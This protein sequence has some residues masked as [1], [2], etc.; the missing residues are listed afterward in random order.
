MTDCG[1]VQ[2]VGEPE[3]RK[4]GA[5]AV[6]DQPQRLQQQRDDDVARCPDLQYDFTQ[7]I[8]SYSRYVD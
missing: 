6:E 3:N 1:S 7:S 5:V 4:G 2:G 8:T